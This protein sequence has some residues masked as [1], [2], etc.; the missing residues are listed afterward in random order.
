M[1]LVKAL[2]LLVLLYSPFAWSQCAAG[3]PNNPGCIPPDV[4]YHTNENGQVVPMPAQTEKFGSFAIDD[5]MQL[6]WGV[7]YDSAQE[8]NNS[9]YK[10]CVDRGGKGC[11]VLEPFRDSCAT[12]AVNPQGQG[13]L[14]IISGRGADRAAEEMAMDECTAHSPEGKCRLL[15]MAICAGTPHSESSNQ[16]AMRASWKDIESR[17]AKLD[18]HHYWGALATD[19]DHMNAVYNQDK[20][21][22]AEQFALEK[23]PGCKV[24]KT[25]EDTCLGTAWPSDK[26]PLFELAT[27]DE[28]ADAKRKALASCNGKYG[29]CDGAVRCSGRRYAKTNPEAPNKPSEPAKASSAN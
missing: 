8:A 18:N 3:I 6:G 1:K 7:N 21:A 29:Q 25:F 19:G 12:Y 17:S 26:R 27:D 5:D 13:F 9:A 16:R 23:C 4:Y 15:G 28:P 2:V 10:S 24:V 20:K 22:T 14:G 11:H